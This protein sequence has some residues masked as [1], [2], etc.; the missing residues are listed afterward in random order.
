MEAQLLA[1]AS[2]FI[3]TSSDNSSSFV[4]AYFVTL[5]LVVLI[6]CT[7]SKFAGAEILTFD[8]VVLT[9][10]LFGLTVWNEPIQKLVS[11]IKGNGV[12]GKLG[13]PD[14]SILVISSFDVLVFFHAR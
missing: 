4:V 1:K 5:Y 6:V 9:P 13:V 10:S 3:R 7:A 2:Q 14:S 8:A 11:S 12:T